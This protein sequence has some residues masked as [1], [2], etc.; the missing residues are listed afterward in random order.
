MLGDVQ[1]MTIDEANIVV[2]VGD[3][4]LVVGVSP[5][6]VADGSGCRSLQQG[7]ELTPQTPDLVA[8]DDS[9]DAITIN[10]A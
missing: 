10:Q 1:G 6:A 4:P 8:F 3:Q 7:F 2:L 9:Q 5:I